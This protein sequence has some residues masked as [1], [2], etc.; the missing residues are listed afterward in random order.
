MSDY[1]AADNGETT[2]DEE[3]TVSGDGDRTHLDDLLG[4]EGP[5][6]ASRDGLGDSEADVVCAARRSTVVVLAGGVRSGKTTLLTSIYEQLNQQPFGQH[7]F[8][9][10]ETLFGFEKRG[11]GWRVGAGMGVPMMERTG[12]RQP[13]WLHLVLRAERDSAPAHPLLLADLSGEHFERLVSGERAPSSLPMLGRADHVG[14]VINGR[15]LAADRERLTE[16]SRV[17]QL[18]RIISTAGVLRSTCVLSIVITKLDRYLEDGRS[19]DLDEQ[20]ARIVRS[21]QLEHEIPAFRTAAQPRSS[22]FPM[23]HGVDALLATWLARDEVSGEGVGQDVEPPATAYERF[24]LAPD[25]VA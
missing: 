4:S 14:V 8:A 19:D 20:V 24:G 6:E 22:R 17:E 2:A 10:S 7:V 5:P 25:S 12:L 9:G 23:G 13:P 15:K 18:L 3:A 16:R 1:T 11:H 21:A